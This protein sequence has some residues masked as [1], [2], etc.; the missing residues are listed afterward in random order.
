LTAER[1]ALKDVPEALF[2]E[3]HEI[4]SA[5]AGLSELDRQVLDAI[6][7]YY[8]VLPERGYASSPVYRA[9]SAVERRT[10]HR[11]HGRHQATGR[12]GTARRSAG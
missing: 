2:A 7:G 12:V 4:A 1:R 11:H 9:D 3:W 10:K 6:V 5:T 8:R